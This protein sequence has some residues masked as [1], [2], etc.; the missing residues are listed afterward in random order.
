MPPE[1][2]AKSSGTSLVADLAGKA[3]MTSAPP[4]SSM[5]QISLVFYNYYCKAYY[6][7]VSDANVPDT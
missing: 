2:F 3:P 6:W 1:F 5:T 4:V 7:E